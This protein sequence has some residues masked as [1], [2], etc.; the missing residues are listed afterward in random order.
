M[1]TLMLVLF[2]TASF[3]HEMTPTYFEPKNSIYNEVY[4]ID[5]LLINR[6]EDQTY[7]EISVLD[8]NF[9]PIVFASKDKL[10]DAKPYARYPF[11]LFVREKDLDRVVY[12]CTVSKTPKGTVN[13]SGVTTRICSKRKT[14]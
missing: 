13:S 12:I 5:M 14:Q 9:E 3:A 1:K 2:S 7:Y 4:E 11:T 6:R 10:I 8:E